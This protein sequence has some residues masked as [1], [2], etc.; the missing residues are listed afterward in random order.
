MSNMQALDEVLTSLRAVAQTERDKGTAFERLVKEFLTKDSLWA[1]KFSDVW[2]WAEWPERNGRGDA[3]IDLVA[4]EFETVSCG[5]YK[6][7]FTP[8]ITR[9]RRATLTHSLR[10]VGKLLSTIA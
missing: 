5:L 9:S 10:R 8:L 2:M 7:S 1:E 4:R 6:R 3:G